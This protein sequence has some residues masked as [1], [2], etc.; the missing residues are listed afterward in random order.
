MWKHPANLPQEIES[1][2][3]IQDL[4]QRGFENWQYYGE[5]N[6][7]ARGDLLLFDYTTRA[8]MAQR[9]NF[10]EQV[11]RGLIINQKTGEIVARPFDKFFYW[12][13]GGRRSKG[14][15]VSIT[16]KLDGSLGILYRHKGAY[17]ITTKGSF[18]SPQA[19]WASE[20]LNRN[21]DLSTLAD[22]LTLMFEIIYPDNQIIVDYGGREELV[23]L[24]ARNRFTGAYLPFF[25]ELYQLGQ[26]YGFNLPK[27]YQFNSLLEI[28][29]QTGLLDP[30]AEGWVVEFSDGQR[31]KFKYDWFIEMHR[32]SRSINPDPDYEG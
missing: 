12:L 27:V 31:F 13:E 4:A 9:W 16:E 29:E 3:Q 21:H 6:V 10:F 22:E 28:L 15:M 32:E 2:Q 11:S 25:P 20:F 8:H 30:N 7:N 23:L 1:L 5:V 26:D 19:R 14:Y 24:A 18:F 17:H